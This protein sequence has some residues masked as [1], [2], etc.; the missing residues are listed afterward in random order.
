MRKRIGGLIAAVGAVMLAG[1]AIGAPTPAELQLL[2]AA[3]QK[4]NAAGNQG[5]CKAG[6][7]EFEQVLKL[8]GFNELDE[9]LRASIYFVTASCAMQLNDKEAA[10]RYALAGSQL[11]G[12]DT[13]LWRL[14]FGLEGENKRYA[15]A[16][17]TL[18]AMAAQNPDALNAMPINWIAN[19]NR[20]L[21]NAGDRPLRRRLLAVVT[22]PDYQP[23]DRATL[24]PPFL[25]DYAA[26]LSDDGDKAGAA[27]VVARIGDPSALMEASVDPRLSAFVPADF[28]A[29][30][31]TERHL[32]RLRDFAASHPGSM[33][34]VL[35]VASDLR[36]LGRP[37][38]ALATLRA[39]SPEGSAAGSFN[40]L[41]DQANWWWDAMGRTYAMLGRY[42]DAVAAFRKGMD[43]KEGGA[44]NVSQT[45]N[46]AFAQI[47]FG[48]PVDAVAT[49]APLD[50]TKTQISP[51]GEMEKRSARGCAHFLAGQPDLT[52]SDI[53]YMQGHERDNPR[54]ITDLLTCVGD[55]D[56]AAASLIR[57]LGDPDRRTQALLYLSDYDPRPASFPTAPYDV[58][59]ERVKTRP[60]VQK[61]IR[62]AG[63][64]RRFN[65]LQSEF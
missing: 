48:H 57:Q 51:Y 13:E 62:E 53:V 4:M 21:R 59:L 25:S 54:A 46:L 31:A 9:Q 45:I 61:A 8:K 36:R 55:L 43:V 29:R 30:A 42:P 16:V 38:E 24:D 63:G 12:A 50:A 10:Y 39:A 22:R 26:L 19:V 40:D 52:R 7:A 44:P 11:K 33:A 41:S 15:D 6:V 34:A 17:A 35:D 32:T 18:E 27:A 37:D 65:V 14:R 2:Q 3:I 58:A 5:G 64:T 49:L 23:V 60:D 56:G 1:P 28:D 47:R 20:A